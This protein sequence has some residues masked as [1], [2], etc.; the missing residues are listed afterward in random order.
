MRH[1]QRRVALVML[2]VAAVAACGAASPSAVTSVVAGVAP[3]AVPGTAP[4]APVPSGPAPATITLEPG[5]ADGPGVSVSDAIANSG[6]GPQ[7]VNGI[8]LK[9]VDSSVWLCEPMQDAPPP[10]CAEPRLLV[11][12]RAPEDQTFVNSDGLH[13]ADG[14]RWVEGVQI[15][16]VVSP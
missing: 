3:T 1:D 14:V 4:M 8:L 11:E 13:E 15:F 2:L 12:G 5:N 6:I 16:G 7:L 10:K 9:A